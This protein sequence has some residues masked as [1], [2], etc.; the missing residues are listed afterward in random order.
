ME[1]LILE[2]FILKKKKIS[3]DSSSQIWYTFPFKMQDLWI[4]GHIFE[5][6]NE[7][8][9]FAYPIFLR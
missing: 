3:I 6:V 2:N 8:P 5:S 7:L 1:T 4:H 9:M